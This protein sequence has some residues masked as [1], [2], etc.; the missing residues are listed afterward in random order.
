MRAFSAPI[1]KLAPAMCAALAATLIAALSLAPSAGATCY[2]ADRHAHAYCTSKDEITPGEYV[3]HMKDANEF[4]KKASDLASQ[5]HIYVGICNTAESE[6]QGPVAGGLKK[7]LNNQTSDLD[8]YLKD[9]S[10]G[11]EFDS[12]IDSVRDRAKSYKGDEQDDVKDGADDMKIGLTELHSAFDA[13]T[14]ANSDLYSLSCSEA[15]L[16]KAQQ[17]ETSGEKHM[18]EGLFRLGKVVYAH[19]HR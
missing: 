13:L 11:S 19:H 2:R 8:S 12:W 1:S 16:E 14:Q 18:V 10:E 4:E 7:V 9:T 6:P 3:A 15:E 17:R 5:D